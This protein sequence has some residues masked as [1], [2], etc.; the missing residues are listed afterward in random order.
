VY[1]RASVLS[2]GDVALFIWHFIT[3][4]QSQVEKASSDSP[5]TSNTSPLSCLINFFSNGQQRCKDRS[6]IQIGWDQLSH[7]GGRYGE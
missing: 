4:Y 5:L 2:L 3:W 7:V 1:V 6:L